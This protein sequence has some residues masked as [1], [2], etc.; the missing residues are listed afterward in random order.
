MAQKVRFVDSVS[1][2]AFGNTGP[3]SVIS[4]SAERKENK[5]VI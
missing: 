4:A 2:S 3:T 1:V 5:S